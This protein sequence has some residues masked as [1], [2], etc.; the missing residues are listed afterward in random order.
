MDKAGSSFLAAEDI[1]NSFFSS[2]TEASQED[3]EGIPGPPALEQVDDFNSPTSHAQNLSQT[4]ESV[5]RRPSAPREAGSRR[6]LRWD[7][8]AAW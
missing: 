5:V 7:A 4:V 3:S 6:R 2:F 1:D 8:Q